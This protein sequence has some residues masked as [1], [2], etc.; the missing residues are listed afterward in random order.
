M[1]FVYLSPHFPPNYYH[2]CIHLND[3]GVNVLGLGDESYDRLRPELRYTLR[4]YYRVND[5]H[6]YDELLRACGYFTHRY[7]RL[8]RIDSH[9]EY[10]LETEAHLRTDFNVVGPKSAD[11]ALLKQKSYIRKLFTKAGLAV[12]QGGVVRTLSDARELIEQLGY[13][14]VA[15]PD[16]GIGVVRSEKI[17]NG[18]ELLAFFAQKLPGNMSI[19][20]YLPGKKF[21]FNGLTDQQ[22]RPVFYTVHTYHPEIQEATN[23]DALTCYYSLRDIPPDLE[24]AGLRLLEIYKIS[25]RFFN[26]EFLRSDETGEIIAREINICPPGGLTS[27]MINFANDIN[28]YQEWANIVVHN[29]FRAQYSHPYYCCYIGRKINKRYVHT[30]EQIIAEFGPLILQHDAFSGVFSAALGNYGYLARSP[31]LDEVLN[32]AAFILKTE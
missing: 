6:Q 20:K 26:F 9:N 2:F 23:D 5:L 22:G 24:A 31:E 25:E 17:H 11:I 12:A 30:H 19:E 27:D 10:W 4:E 28:I 32:I 13:P 29:R 15:R 14:V 3:L 21:T 8:N 1:N 16:R 7:G 18:T